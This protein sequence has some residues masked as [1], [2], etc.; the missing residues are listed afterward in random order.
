MMMLNLKGTE[1]YII[2]LVTTVLPC[3]CIAVVLFIMI[4]YDFGLKQRLC[5]AY[6]TLPEKG[7]DRKVGKIPT[8][9]FFGENALIDTTTATAVTDGGGGKRK[10]LRNATVKVDSESVSLLVLTKENFNKLVDTGKLNRQVLA[11]ME[12][13]DLERQAEHSSGGD[14]GGSGSG[15][16]EMSV[17]LGE[18]V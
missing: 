4:M 13:V 1:Q 8:F 7:K 15:S 17:D 9:S 12:K 11:G 3:L 16:N 18:V 14:G 10:N 5:G 2:E 6:I